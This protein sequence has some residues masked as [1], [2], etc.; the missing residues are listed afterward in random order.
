MQPVARAPR[1]GVLVGGVLIGPCPPEAEALRQRVVRATDG[2]VLAVRDVPIRALPFA[3]V[4]RGEIDW[5]APPAAE[6][7]ANPTRPAMNMLL[8]PYASANLPPS[9][10]RLPKASR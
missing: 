5:A 8:R 9:G 3:A 4:A 1:G 2:S 10:S 6:A 7:I